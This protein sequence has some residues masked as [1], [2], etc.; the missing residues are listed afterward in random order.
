VSKGGVRKSPMK[1]PVVVKIQM[2]PAG[3]LSHHSVMKSLPWKESVSAWFPSYLSLW[4]R[5]EGE[6]KNLSEKKGI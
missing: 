5:E 6:R 3:V 4:L 2:V 1:S